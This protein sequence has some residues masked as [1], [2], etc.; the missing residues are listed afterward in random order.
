MSKVIAWLLCG[1]LLAAP[2]VHADERLALEATTAREPPTT[3]VNLRLGG[4]TSSRRAELCG[5][6]APHWRVSVEGCGSGRE[7]LH[8]E[9][10]PEIAHFRAKFTFTRLRTALGWLEPR[11]A[12]GF[13]EFQLGADD[14]GFDFTSVNRTRTATSGPEAGAALRWS[15]PVVAGFELLVE[16]NVSLA[17]FAFAP[18]LETPQAVLQPS[19]SV[20][21]GVGF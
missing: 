19:A 9:A 7:F 12:L 1:V 6:V 5:E 17:V 4:S 13:A 2:A 18:L 10:N 8:H 16:M 15:V 11:A 21:A 20:S 3:Y 14:P